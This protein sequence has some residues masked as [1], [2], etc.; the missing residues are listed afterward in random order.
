MEHLDAN[1]KVFPPETA[2]VLEY[3]LDV[4]LASDWKKP[5]VELPWHPD[6]FIQD[7]A[8]YKSRGISDVTSFAVYMDSTYFSVYPGKE[9]LEDYG[10]I[11]GVCR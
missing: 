5:A 1:L 11:L 2:V 9:C 6:V 7:L 10:I 8:V 3:W 4:S